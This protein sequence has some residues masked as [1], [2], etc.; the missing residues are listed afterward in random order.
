LVGV[1]PEG[2]ASIHEEDR[3][4]TKHEFDE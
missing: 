4:T 3:K 2:D 1:H